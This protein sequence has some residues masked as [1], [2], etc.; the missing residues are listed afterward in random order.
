MA[1][2]LARKVIVTKQEKHG[3]KQNYLKELIVIIA[4][5]RCQVQGVELG[6]EIE[7]R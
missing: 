5:C 7:S 1:L 4:R 3:T 6:T 2:P